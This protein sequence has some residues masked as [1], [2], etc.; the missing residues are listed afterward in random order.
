MGS[1]E[2]NKSQG[3]WAKY[4][5]VSYGIRR[6]SY[7]I[8]ALAGAYLVYLMYQLFTDASNT[9]EELTVVLAAAGVLIMAAG[10]YFV[11]GGAYALLNGIYAENELQDEP[12]RIGQKA[13]AADVPMCEDGVNAKPGEPDAGD[14]G[15]VE[16]ES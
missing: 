5:L 4:L 7:L 11:I 1:M 6:A 12:E 16:S 10:I 3:R 15:S 9:G 14:A 13:D 8:R 2:K